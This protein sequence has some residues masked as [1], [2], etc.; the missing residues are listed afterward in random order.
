MGL[1]SNFAVCVQN[2]NGSTSIRVYFEDVLPDWCADNLTAY[3]SEG[4]MTCWEGSECGSS[5][6]FLET[7]TNCVRVKYYELQIDK[8]WCKDFGVMKRTGLPM[9]KVL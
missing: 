6:V 5:S 8:N 3:D 9:L 1:D 2:L 4:A 7:A